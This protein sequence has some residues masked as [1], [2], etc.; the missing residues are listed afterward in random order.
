MTVAGGITLCRVVAAA[1]PATMPAFV[2]KAAT[3][4][5]EVAEAAQVAHTARKKSLAKGSEEDSRVV[6]KA[7][8]NSWGALRGRLQM[9]ALLPETTYPDAKRAG[10]IAASLFGESGLSFLTEKYPEQYAIAESILRRIDGESMA[11]D[12]DRIAGKEFL[13]NVRTQHVAYGNM[14]A[15]VLKREIGLSEDLSEHI[16]H[17]GQ[18]LVEYATKV[19][20]SVD[21]D[22]PE[23]IISAQTALQPIDVF[24][25][26]AQA[27]ASSGGHAA[28]TPEGSPNE[29]TG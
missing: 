22:T 10:E 5:V 28:E 21:R 3:R 15:A 16:D 6:D 8:D 25:D 29:A 14:V 18:A 12:I 26:A 13:E 11:D 1:C 27:H 20:A 19:L 7:G 9:Y 2:K 4:L 24:R 17:L 23:T